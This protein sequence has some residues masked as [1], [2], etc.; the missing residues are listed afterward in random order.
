MKYVCKKA[1]NAHSHTIIHDYTGKYKLHSL[2]TQ[3]Y[4]Q[5][6]PY[7]YMPCLLPSLPHTHTLTA[8]GVLT[9]SLFQ[10]TLPMAS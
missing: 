6:L 2:E 4:M 10:H 8:N 5:S 1:H 7:T 9:M 3:G